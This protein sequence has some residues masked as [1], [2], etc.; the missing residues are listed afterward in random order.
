[1]WYDK[2]RR[3]ISGVD[4]HNP[5]ISLNVTAVAVLHT[6]KPPTYG[7]LPDLD[8]VAQAVRPVFAYFVRCVGLL[9]QSSTVRNGCV[10]RTWV[11]APLDLACCVPQL[12][13][14]FVVGI[15]MWNLC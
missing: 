14:R 2:Y 6:T 3:Y 13:A 7:G 11:R 1:M 8:A 9:L 12:E 5:D 15:E 10:L 4:P